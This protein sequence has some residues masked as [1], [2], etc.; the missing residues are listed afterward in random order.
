MKTDSI[1]LTIHN[2][3]WLIQEVVKKI[4]SN[5][6]SNVELIFVFDGCTDSSEKKVNEIIPLA[7]ANFTIKQLHTPDVYETKANN[8][9]MRVATGDYII[10]V[11]DDM[12]INEKNWNLRLRKPVETF[13]DIFAV[14]SRT[15]HNWVYNPHSIHQHMVENLDNCW[16][17][18][19]NHT[20]HAHSKNIDRN[21]FAIRDSVNRGPLL[22]RHDI[23]KTLNYLDEEFAP[24]DMD[25]HDLCYRAYKQLGMKAGCY[26]INCQSEDAWG[27]TRVNGSPAKWL[28]K[29]NHKNVKIVWQRH[30]DLI[31]GE[32][33]NENRFL[34]E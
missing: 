18:I 10:I 31:L 6:I 32:K 24:Q 5:T 28:L 34:K 29:A 1:I 4:F 22:L 27:G 20:D 14:T 2:K 7:P 21:T 23:M 19:I 3:E 33:H 30:K 13:S 9:G 11:Q 12:L 15:A 16:C 26:W 17:D 25:D 8:A